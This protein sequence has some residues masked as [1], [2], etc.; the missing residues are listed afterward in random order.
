MTTTRLAIALALVIPSLA[1]A[2]GN[3]TKRAA[4]ALE[5]IAS[6]ERTCADLEVVLAEGDGARG[7]VFVT[8]DG[9]TVDTRRT[10]YKRP[11]KRWQAPVKETTCQKLAYEIVRGRLWQTRRLRDYGKTG[12]TYPRIT[13]NIAGVGRFQVSQWSGDV[14]R[15][16][17]FAAVR[18]MMTAWATPPT[19]R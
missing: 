17:G 5:A 8:L 6:G 14:S 15:S 16:P 2:K 3:Q 10:Y 4:D 13:V 1:L 19:S 18:K 7:W 12:E 11:Y 9:A